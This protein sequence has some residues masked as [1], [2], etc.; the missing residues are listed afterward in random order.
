MPD[1]A[2]D[3]SPDYDQ[4]IDLGSL[5]GS[6]GIP[7]SM[8]DRGQV[9][10]ASLLTGDLEAHPFLSEQGKPMVDLGTFGGIGRADSINQAGDVVGI[11]APPGNQQGFA[12]LWKNGVMQNLGTVDGDPCSEGLS[13]NAREQVVGASWD[14]GGEFQHSFLWENG[15]MV[16]LLNLVDTPAGMQFKVPASINDRGEIAI[17]GIL[18]NGDYHAILLIP[19]DDDHVG[20]EGCDYSKVEA[21]AA[22]VPAVPRV[23][24]ERYRPQ[25]TGFRGRHISRGLTP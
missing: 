4:M 11:A 12:F 7:Y 15:S 22:P 16:D 3:Y 6:M 24:F 21:T 25:A 10:G 17:Q 19:C 23:P 2:D 20:I 9:V 18:A 8:N 5:G 14:C 13:I 1:N